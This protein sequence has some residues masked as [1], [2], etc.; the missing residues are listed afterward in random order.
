MILSV[1]SW[2]SASSWCLRSLLAWEGNIIESIL[3]TGQYFIHFAKRF[4]GLIRFFFQQWR[5]HPVGRRTC[6]RTG[7]KKSE[8]SSTTSAQATCPWKRYLAFLYVVSEHFVSVVNIPTKKLLV[9]LPLLEELSPRS[10]VDNSFQ[11]RV[12]WPS[13]L[14]YGKYCSVFSR[15]LDAVGSAVVGKWQTRTFIVRK[16]EV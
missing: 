14:G 13:S 15:S 9:I 7:E 16:E 6:C 11:G 10:L 3:H 2:M 5:Y 12:S 1:L 8:T 4:Y